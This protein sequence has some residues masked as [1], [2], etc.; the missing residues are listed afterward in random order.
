MKTLLRIGAVLSFLFFFVGG[1]CILSRTLFSPASDAFIL[2]A[3]GFFFVGTAFFAG[4][5]LL[6]AAEKLTRHGENK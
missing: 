5:M 2:A 3:V 6:I 1:C 4:P